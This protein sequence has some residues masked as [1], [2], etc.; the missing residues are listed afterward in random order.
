MLTHL[1]AT[2]TKPSRVVLLG[3]SGFLSRHLQIALTAEQIPQLVLGSRDCDLT[4]P[5]SADTLAGQLQP[6]DTLVM[7]STLTPE[8]G[9]G[10]EITM[11]NLR[12][13]ESVCRALS[14]VRCAHLIYVSSD[15]VYDGHQT[16]LDE[17]STRE[18]I[19]LYA[20][21]HTGREMM[22]AS[23]LSGSG[24]PYCIL[25]PTNVYGP[26][27]THNN[28]GP[29]RFVRSALREGRIVLFGQGEELRSQVFATDAARLISLAIL[30]RSTGILNLAN[31]PAVS[32]RNVANE[33]IR[34]AG[35]PVTLEFAERKVPPVHRP[36]KITQVAR[37]IYN[38]GRPI[39]PIVHRTFSNSA[40]F[41]AFPGFSFTPLAEGLKQFVQSERSG[42]S[43]P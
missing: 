40:T 20:L 38:L 41:H 13:A 4:Q 10:Y 23:V 6:T 14:R 35:R 7:L 2:A 32:F 43:Q 8:K 15:A 34:L 25:R 36:Y 18:P 24:T 37:F 30:H 16:P 28:Y 26:G 42:S 9:R 19:D 5:A 3:G 17:D 1:H 22:L 29:N 12:M 21:M 39:G 31:R 27:D 11:Q 33:V